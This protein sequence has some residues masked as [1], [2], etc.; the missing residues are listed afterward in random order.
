MCIVMCCMYSSVL[1]T[2]T[3]GV[4]GKQ[5]RAERKYKRRRER[6]EDKVWA[7]FTKIDFE[8]DLDIVDSQTS[9]RYLNQTVAQST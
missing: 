8:Y 9:D 6:R 2:C 4:F 5:G 1:Y 3:R 7:G